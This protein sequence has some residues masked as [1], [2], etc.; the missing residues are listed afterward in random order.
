MK[1]MT[2]FILAAL[3]ATTLSP[4]ITLADSQNQGYLV[5]MNGNIV[6]TSNTDLCWRDGDWTP[7][8]SIEPCDPNNKPVAAKP[9]A[10]VVA[11]APA[12]AIPQPALAKPL[13]EKMSF[14]ADA[15]FAFDKST[16]KPEGKTMLDD[17]VRQLDGTTYDV[18]LAT[19]HTD[20]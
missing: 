6:T 4:A 2:R 9:T 5:D 17:L 18:I 11:A 15:L 13:L 12:A 10:A 1:T 3:A 16:L 8:R 19:G 14:S 7:A 20:R